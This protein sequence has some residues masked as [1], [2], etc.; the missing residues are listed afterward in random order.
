MKFNKET[1][2]SIV[3]QLSAA[4][5]VLT[6]GRKYG[7]RVVATEEAIAELQQADHPDAAIVVSNLA[8]LDRVCRTAK[9]FF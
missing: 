4:M 1:S 9:S 3:S 6:Q 2:Y 7:I 5:D 8:P